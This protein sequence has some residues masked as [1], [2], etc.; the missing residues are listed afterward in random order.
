MRCASTKRARERGP[1]VAFA[2]MAFRLSQFRM[3]VASNSVVAGI[4]LAALLPRWFTVR[5]G[6]YFTIAFVFVMQPWTLLDCATS[7]L[8]VVG[9][10][11][12]F[13]GPLM[14][15]MF[16]DYFLLRRTTVKLTALYGS[17]PQSSIYWYTGG[18]N[19]RAVVAWTVGVWLFLPRLAQRAVAPKDVWPGGMRLYQL[20]WFLGCLVSGLVYLLLDYVWPIQDKLVVDDADCFGTFDDLPVIQGVDGPDQTGSGVGSLRLN[21]KLAAAAFAMEEKVLDV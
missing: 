5:R 20:A 9:S 19:L 21:E 15:I 1:G 10:L 13:L 18:W 4:D 12:V 8:T 16:A 2:S 6:G 17:G 11:S 14:G 7:F 3:V